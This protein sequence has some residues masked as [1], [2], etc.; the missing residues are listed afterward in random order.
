MR[1]DTNKMDPIGSSVLRLWDGYRQD[2]FKTFIKIKLVFVKTFWELC[3][4]ALAAF[5]IN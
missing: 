1:V 4:T 5:L 3:F 2:D